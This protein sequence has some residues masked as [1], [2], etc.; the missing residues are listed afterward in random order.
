MVRCTR[1]RPARMAS[2]SI[3][4]AMEVYY[5]YNKYVHIFIFSLCNIIPL[6][7]EDVLG[8]GSSELSD[9][10]SSG[11]LDASIRG[12]V[13]IKCCPP[14]HPAPPPTPA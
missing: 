6:G 2:Y 10:R 9:L 12:R 5:F 13:L 7:P 11:P 4:D 3:S 1:D 8:K 14:S